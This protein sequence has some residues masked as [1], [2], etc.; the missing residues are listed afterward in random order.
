[1]L[2]TSPTCADVDAGPYSF[3]EGRRRSG[4]AARLLSGRA[5]GGQIAGGQIAS[6]ECC[7]R[8]GRAEDFGREA[9][10]R[11]ASEEDRGSVRGGKAR[12]VSEQAGV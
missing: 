1:V 2:A 11:Y 9:L 12:Q 4:G 3:L 5:A 6:G 8:R 7:G 10:W